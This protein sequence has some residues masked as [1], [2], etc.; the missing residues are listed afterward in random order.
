[1]R[2]ARP[3]PLLVAVADIQLTIDGTSR[4]VP[5]GTTILDAAAAA[6]IHVPTLCSTPDLPPPEDVSADLV[7]QHRE[8]RAEG[9]EPA[10]VGEGCGVCVVKANGEMVRSCVTPVA[11]GMVVDTTANPLL[12]YHRRKPG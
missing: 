6:G 12:T 7:E 11:E 2:A 5:E 1:M 3:L 10:P 4:V 9:N 8:V